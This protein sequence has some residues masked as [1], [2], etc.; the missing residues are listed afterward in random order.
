MHDDVGQIPTTGCNVLTGS[1][2]ISNYNSN[3]KKDFVF[4]GSK[5]Y[6]YRT[7]TSNYGNYDISS[8]NCI[9]VT[10]L[11]SNS[12]FEPFIYGI[13]FLLFLVAVILFYKTIKGFLHVI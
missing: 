3:T 2:Y 8:Y 13:G 10:K 1:S 11:N 12:V 7:Q 5:W 9:D 4:N 6:L